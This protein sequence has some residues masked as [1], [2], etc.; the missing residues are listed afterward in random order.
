MM[1]ALWYVDGRFTSHD[2]QQHTFKSVVA[3]TDTATVPDAAKLFSERDEKL[4]SVKEIKL[5]VSFQVPAN[6]L[7]FLADQT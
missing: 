4:E 6:Q 1:V 7:D 2:G 5:L 3:T